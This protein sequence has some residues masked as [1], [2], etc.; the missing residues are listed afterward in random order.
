MLSN[1]DGWNFIAQAFSAVVLAEGSSSEVLWDNPR[2]INYLYDLAPAERNKIALINQ[3]YLT[4]ATRRIRNAATDPN[5]AESE[6]KQAFKAL[7]EAGIDEGAINASIE[8]F[9]SAV[10]S[11]YEAY[12]SL[13][14]WQKGR[15]ADSTVRFIALQLSVR[16]WNMAKA[17]CDDT[18]KQYPRLSEPYLFRLMALHECSNEVD[19]IDTNLDLKDSSDFQSSV[20]YASSKE[21]QEKLFRYQ[22]VQEQKKRKYYAIKE[23]R[24]HAQ[25]EQEYL[26]WAEECKSILNFRN[27]RQLRE[28]CMVDAQRAR[29]CEMTYMIAYGYL[30]SARKL[31]ALQ[32]WVETAEAFR[33]AANLFNKILSYKDSK[34]LVKECRNPAVYL[35]AVGLM[36]QAQS[37][38]SFREAATA[39]EAVSCFGDSEIRRK[40][41]IEQAENCRKE[42]IYQE[43]C[44]KLGEAKKIHVF[45]W[46]KYR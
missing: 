18:I 16:N 29:S 37:E 45:N 25:T 36:E 14:D 41:C 11:L 35:N 24:V 3:I 44:K 33:S 5:S 7:K 28:V 31:Q 10:P 40:Q 21:R 39:F 46:R 2:M 15:N 32:K 38:K 42:I 12:V 17:L 23:G 19:L 20:R 26:K 13:L 4:G 43:A 34:Q 30:D 22:E 1:S 8:C 27:T 6:L 9:V